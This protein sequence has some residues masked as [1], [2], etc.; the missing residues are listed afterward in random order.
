MIHFL[1]SLAFVW[2]VSG[3]GFAKIG[4]I[5]TNKL[6]NSQYGMLTKAYIRSHLYTLVWQVEWSLWGFCPQSLTIAPEYLGET[7]DFQISYLVMC[8]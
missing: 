2:I 5:P 7:K 6:L 1:A 3:C 4:F 8:T